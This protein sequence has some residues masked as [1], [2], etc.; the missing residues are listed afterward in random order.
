M[1]IGSLI[2]GNLKLLNKDTREEIS[3][4]PEGNRLVIFPVRDDTWHG[5]PERVNSDRV[6]AS[7]A[8]HFYIEMLD[9][10]EKSHST[11]YID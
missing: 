1:M 4:T 2:G 6:R 10:T 8:M 3:Y 7:F 9:K 5:N 11:I